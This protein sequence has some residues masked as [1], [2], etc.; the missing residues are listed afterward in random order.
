MFICICNAVS[1]DQLQAAFTRTGNWER[2]AAEC[3][4][5]QNCGTCMEEVQKF[6]SQANEPTIIP[7]PVLA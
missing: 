4:A 5:G 1:G 6:L 7:L 2:A 3:G